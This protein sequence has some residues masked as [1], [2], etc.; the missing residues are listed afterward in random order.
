MTKNPKNRLGNSKN[1]IQ[2]I[3]NHPFFEG[4]NWEELAYKQS[5][6]PFKPNLT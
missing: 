5:K 3:K 4:I 6:P 1:G 2:D